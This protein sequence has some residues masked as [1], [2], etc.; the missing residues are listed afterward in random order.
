MHY[1]HWNDFLLTERFVQLRK[2]L[3]SETLR[4][5][6]WDLT[7]VVGRGGRR[8]YICR[9]PVP[10]SA[11]LAVFRVLPAF[12]QQYYLCMNSFTKFLNTPRQMRPS[13]S[14]LVSYRIYE[15][16]TA[17]GL[18]HNIQDTAHGLCKN[19]HVAPMLACIYTMGK[20]TWQHL[21]CGPLTAAHSFPRH[22]FCLRHYVYLVIHG[23]WDILH[24]RLKM[25]LFPLSSS[26]S[27]ERITNLSSTLTSVGDIQY[28]VSYPLGGKYHPSIH[29]PYIHHLSWYPFI[30]WSLMQLPS[31]KKQ[32]TTRSSWPALYKAN[33]N[34][35]LHTEGQFRAMNSPLP[36]WK[37]LDYVKTQRKPAQTQ[38]E[39]E[40][41]TQKSPWPT[42]RPCCELLHHRAKYKRFLLKHHCLA[43]EIVAN[44]TDTF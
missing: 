14:C 11:S 4:P 1:F 16:K 27:V 31:G 34:A 38:G 25:C 21:Q 39:H 5:L 37:P 8:I 41:Y 3:P 33:R 13:V 22:I 43:K 19:I 17:W 26:V 7:R 9:F 20:V 6:A 2:V 35:Q 10:E 29:R 44:K 42:R 15:E 24:F 40:K 28:T 23:R 18:T 30:G 36:K 32:G 12:A